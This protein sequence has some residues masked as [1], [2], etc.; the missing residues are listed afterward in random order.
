MLGITWRRSAVR[1]GLAVLAGVPV[2]HG[3]PLGQL[4]GLGDAEQVLREVTPVVAP[5]LAVA[6]YWPPQ[7][8]R[9]R[10]YLHLLDDRGDAVAFV[11]LAG[12]ADAPAL[13]REE[14]A[15]ASLD[16]GTARF[17]TP[18]LRAAGVAG[19]T[20]WLCTDPL[21]AFG[22]QTLKAHLS[23]PAQVVDDIRGETR[24]VAASELDSLTWWADLQQRLDGAPRAF[25]DDLAVAVADG[26]E[27]GRGHGD[28]GAH[29]LASAA[30]RLWVFDW[31]AFAPDAPVDQD[32][33]GFRLH[34]GDE[35]PAVAGPRGEAAFARFVACCAFGL[36]H[37][38]T[39]FCTIV[40]RWTPETP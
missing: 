17:S 5:W 32:V 36:A 11:K 20:R 38:V 12:G 28:F 10:A 27:V 4:P 1:T 3:T 35:L 30:G 2:R 25:V 39:R 24:Q 8:E 23:L 9:D 16:G 13:A 37:D 26:L 6:A 33:V 14:A 18:R 29:N 15:L 21:P 22:R 19:P 40:R 31:E 7:P 34:R